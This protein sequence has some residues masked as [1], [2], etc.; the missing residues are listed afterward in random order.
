[1]HGKYLSLYATTPPPT[2]TPTPLH[3]H[4]PNGGETWQRGASHMV[5]WSYTGSPGLYVKIVLLKAGTEVGTIASSVSI[6]GSGAGSYTWPISTTGLTGNDFKVSVQSI[7]QQTIK[8]TSNNY[9]TITPAT[10]TPT[11]TPTQPDTYS[12]C[13]RTNEGGDS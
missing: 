3:H 1:M 8:D 2:P 9:F 12:P 11:L 5:N 10:P 7:S 4:V 13:Q 6:G